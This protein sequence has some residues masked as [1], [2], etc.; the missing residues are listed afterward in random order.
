LP[1][2]RLQELPDYEIERLLGRGDM[3]ADEYIVEALL[4][5]KLL[6]GHKG[7]KGQRVYLV[8]WEG[9][10]PSSDTWEP[11]ENFTGAHCKHLI[12]ELSVR[13]RDKQ[14]SKRRREPVQGAS[15]VEEAQGASN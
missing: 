1:P 2:L 13:V 15:S 14:A 10:P 8:R 6:K 7:G 12:Q 9:Y 11:A 5:T 3:G 4:D